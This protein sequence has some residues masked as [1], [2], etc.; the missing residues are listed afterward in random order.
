MNLVN[1]LEQVHWSQATGETPPFYHEI[2]IT[3]C[4]S[5][6]P[7]SKRDIKRI[8]R[9]AYLEYKQLGKPIG[10]VDVNPARWAALVMDKVAKGEAKIPNG[11]CSQ[12]SCYMNLFYDIVAKKM[13]PP[14]PESVQTIM[15][16]QP[17][18]SS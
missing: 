8:S 4:V 13:K 16:L 10:S 3:G 6:Y 14:N 2:D 17:D 12:K 1:L 9:E 15:N 18:L 5:P 7:H 11:C